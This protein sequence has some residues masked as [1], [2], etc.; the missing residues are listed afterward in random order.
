MIFKRTKN[1][2]NI[3]GILVLSILCYFSNIIANEDKIIH[4][5]Q[6]HIEDIGAECEDCHITIPK[7]KNANDRN[8][9][10][11]E[12]CYVCHDDDTASQEC[13]T[14]HSNLDD[15]KVLPDLPIRDYYFDHV[16]HIEDQEMECTDCHKGLEEVE[17]AVEE[18]YSTMEQCFECHNDVVA[19]KMCES[20]HTPEAVLTP[21]S[22]NSDWVIIHK[23]LAKI[24]ENE[25]RVCHQDNYCEDCHAGTLLLAVGKGNRDYLNPQTPGSEGK[26]NMVLQRVHSLNYRYVHGIDAN[27]KKMNCTV[28]QEQS[29]FCVRCHQEDEKILFIKPS[30]HSDSNWGAIVDAVGSG[31]GRHAQ[32][33][34][35]DI[36]KCASCHDSQGEDPTCLMCHR[37]FLPG[38]G[39]DLKTHSPGRFSGLGEGAYHID[40]GSICYN[41]HINTMSPG[42]GFCGYCHAAK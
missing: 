33:A 23:H 1:I 20:C 19:S 35:R 17:Y 42:I 39:N 9:P 41:C 14:C 24:K 31:G 28:C 25:C 40:E 13:K 2:I 22:H 34:R 36:E 8:L 4:S 37:D 16:L 27:S 6:L 26:K 5:H 30:W 32:L 10:T 29:Q 21:Q 12:E 38:K 3:T 11:H 18:S 7:S 15:P